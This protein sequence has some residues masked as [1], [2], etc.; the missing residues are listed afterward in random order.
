V[1]L[2]VCSPDFLNSDF[3]RETELRMLYQASE[4]G[5]VKLLPIIVKDCGWRQIPEISEL[6]AC[7]YEDRPLDECPPHALDGVFVQL[8][9]DINAHL[10]RTNVPAPGTGIERTNFSPSNTSFIGRGREIGELK[11][12]VASKDV[13]LLTLTGSPGLGKT[14][15]AKQLGAEMVGDFPGGCWFVSLVDA[16]TLTGIAHAIAQV[17]NVSVS[18]GQISD[19]DAI[20][21]LLRRREKSLLILDNFEQVVKLAGTSVGYWIDR[22][23]QITFLVTSREILN[24]S[25]ERAYRLDAL[26]LPPALD[27][28]EIASY[29]SVRLFFE[30]AQRE[31]SDLVFDGETTIAAARI[32]IELEGIPLAIELAAARAQI[33]TIPE[34]ADRIRQK[35]SFLRGM[36]R[37]QHSRQQTI[38][39]SIDWSFQLLTPWE[40]SAFLQLCIFRGGFSLEAAERIV[41]L[42]PF[43][44]P[45][46]YDVVQSLLGKC[47]LEEHPTRYSLRFHMLVAIQEYGQE[48]WLK[49]APPERQEALARRWAA[50]YVPY[51]QMWNAKVHSPEGVKALDLLTLELE[52]IFGAQ[53][54]S[55]E[56]GDGETAAQA[57]LAFSEAMAMRGPAHLRV[58]RLEKSLA[59]IGAQHDELRMRLMNELAAAHWS[60]GQWNEATE[61]ADQAVALADQLRHSTFAAAALRLQGR[62]RTDRGYLRRALSSLESARQIYGELS[63]PS[64]IS[65]ISCDM[66]AVFDR[67]GDLQTSLA[68]VGEAEES[69]RASGDETQ[70]A[71]VLNRRGLAL[72]HHGDPE[73]AL[74][75]FEEAERINAALGASAWIG[76][77]RTNQGLALVDL[78]DFERAAERFAS[79][80]KIHRELGTQAWAAVNYGGLGRALLMRAAPGDLEAALAQFRTAAEISRRVYY[81]ENISQHAGDIGRCLFLLGHEEEARQAVREAVSLERVIGA[82]KDLRHFGNLV[83]LAR[84]ARALG[85]TEEC[86]EAVFRARDL[87]H[88]LKLGKTHR[89]KRVAEDLEALA[90][91][92]DR[93]EADDAV[94]HVSSLLDRHGSRPLDSAELNEISALVASSFDRLSYEYPWTG[95]ENDLRT[96]KRSTIRLFGYGSL[97]NQ[98]SA[99]R[100]F[101]GAGERLTAAIAFGVIRLFNFE[102]PDV[103]RARYGGIS[104]DDPYR[105]LLNAQVTGFMTDVANGV[106]PRN[107]AI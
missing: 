44:A 66:A 95:L 77:H 4:E 87:Q 86:R 64:G 106:L 57:I 80:A 92:V 71:L 85:R 9:A 94:S 34:I 93:L 49:T 22:L 3:I 10:D 31:R 72:W 90:E 7:M 23:P 100:T 73:N 21:Q 89:V 25:A 41:D 52:N 17:F 75:A 48:A 107:C 63:S 38:Y 43:E 39:S 33:F 27:A 18:S 5:R 35:F 67:L 45:P 68:L 47:L 105:G 81:P 15:L 79:A 88:R 32:C 82:N 99:L 19:Q 59:A 74:A 30:R 2:L 46:V 28:P 42:S 6:Q 36:R 60:L 14:R 55:I 16:V 70:R 20:V 26:A 61:L 62:I 8:A 102:M 51:A 11:R 104:D 83:T 29:E 12:L 69:A 65:V 98:E 40:Q 84:I 50:Y 58:P 56:H 101:A 1:A 103:V 54:W 76:A 96:Q 53:D 78:G 13:R 91:I 97:V 37:D 24:L